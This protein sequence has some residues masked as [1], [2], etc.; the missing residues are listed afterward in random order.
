MAW[1]R[2]EGG[3]DAA[4][5]AEGVGTISL[6]FGA[7]QA[8]VFL[9]AAILAATF[10][11]D[12]LV[13]ERRMRSAAG[14][15]LH[16]LIVL[17]ASGIVLTFSGSPLVASLFVLAIV[18]ALSLISNAKN[19]ML[20]EPL[21]FSDLNLLVAVFRHPQFYLSAL[22]PWQVAALVVGAA[23]LAGLMAWL[24]VADLVPHLVGAGMAVAA[25][26]LIRITLTLPPWRDLA[27]IPDSRADLARH[28][29]LASLLMYR[30]RWLASA[31]PAPCT[32]GLPAPATAALV[33][34]VQCE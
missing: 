6:I 26:L 31:D 27:A 20:G 24:F 16:L 28:G 4:G 22:L 33:V 3:L 32:A 9:P 7:F 29:L 11:A 12:A 18:S 17:A 8:D 14:L 25:V 13:R 19:A 1:S 30:Q 5:V 34:V 2:P 10:V 15:W 23:G 21:V